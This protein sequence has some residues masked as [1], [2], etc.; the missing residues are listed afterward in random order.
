MTDALQPVAPVRLVRRFVG[1]PEQRDAVVIESWQRASRASTAVLG[2][3]LADAIVAGYTVSGLARLLHLDTSYVSRLARHGHLCLH[4][5]EQD[6][7]SLDTLP[8]EAETREYLTDAWKA[9]AAQGDV[10]VQEVGS[11]DLLRSAAVRDAHGAL[12][13]SSEMLP[14]PDTGEDVAVVQEHDRT[15]ERRMVRACDAG[16]RAVGRMRKAMSN[17][18]Q[19]H[20]SWSAWADQVGDEQEVQ[21]TANDLR[22]S[23]RHLS[24]AADEL[25]HWVDEQGSSRR[26]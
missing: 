13:E 9:A 11:S 22:T 10:R 7:E 5:L 24:T 17:T 14:L 12:M 4:L 3:V 16:R 23:A 8:G 25:Q 15:R 21:W 20:G 18:V 2:I 6:G 26:T 19:A 1:P